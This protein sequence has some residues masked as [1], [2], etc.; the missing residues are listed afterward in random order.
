M[1]SKVEPLEIAEAGGQVAK[2]AGFVV[3]KK[4]AIIGGT[5]LAAVFVGVIC[6]TYFG[7]PD[8]NNDETTIL[9]PTTVMTTARTL[10]TS[11]FNPT[12]PII[13]V[14]TQTPLN[15]GTLT[16]V[17]TGNVT[18]TTP[19]ILSNISTET[20]VS[21]IFQTTPLSNVSIENTTSNIFGTTPLG[22]SNSS[23]ITISTSSSTTPIG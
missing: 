4:M 9:S 18:A 20:T 8:A 12:T 23:E 3:T 21:N 6:A 17:A 14:T 5:L 2:A 1:S 13:Q 7:K 10:T 11:L 22:I 15:T 19:L 16:Q